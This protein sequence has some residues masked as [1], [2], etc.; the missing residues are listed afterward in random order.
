M[1]SSNDEEDPVFNSTVRTSPSLP[2]TTLTIYGPNATFPWEGLDPLEVQGLPLARFVEVCVVFVSPVELEHITSTTISRHD[3]P[4]LA[5]VSI[6]FSTVYLPSKRFH[7]VRCLL[8]SATTDGLVLMAE[9]RSGR[10]K[11][12]K[13]VWN[14]GL[15]LLLLGQSPVHLLLL[16]FLR[17]S[18]SGQFEWRE[19]VFPIPHLHKKPYRRLEH[20]LAPS[21][22]E[23][24]FDLTFVPIFDYLSDLTFCAYKIGPIIEYMNLGG[25]LLFTNLLK[26]LMKQSDSREVASSKCTAPEFMHVNIAPHLLT[27]DLPSLIFRGP[28]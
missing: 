11:W 7:A 18:L 4:I 9:G 6:S 28:K 20:P 3:H 12:H 13:E 10:L 27:T 15:P 5:S 19:S 16:D 24:V 26:T 21:L 8:F 25:P 1:G 17:A 2:R 23:F 22:Q 14:K